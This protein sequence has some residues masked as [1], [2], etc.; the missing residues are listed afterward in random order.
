ME[1]KK[2]APLRSKFNKF[3]ASID[4]DMTSPLDA[5]N[6]PCRGSLGLLGKPEAQPVEVWTAGQPQ[7]LTLTG[8]AAHGG[9]SCQ[10][11]LSYDNGKTWK[12]IHSWVGECPVSGESS[13][14]FTVPSDAPAGE[15]LFAWSW[16]NKI[17]NREMYMN[18]AV[19]TI[20]SACASSPVPGKFRR[21]SAPF[22]SRPNMFV[23]NIN[24]GCGTTEGTDVEFP[25][26]GPDV[27]NK[28]KKTSKPVGKCPSS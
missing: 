5:K 4:Y 10:A 12:V 18:C 28:S 21:S 3:K 24:N 15:A 25:N 20:K 14:K 7:S 9:G 26:P 6:F 8:G 13:Y 22:S 17:G 16:F 19:I 27:D 23:A 1:M 11:S 2:P